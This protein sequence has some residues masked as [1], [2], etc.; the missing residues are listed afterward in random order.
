ML[1]GRKAALKGDAAQH[2]EHWSGEIEPLKASGIESGAIIVDALFG[3]GLARPLTREVIE[4]IL[5]AER[6]GA[7]VYSVDVPSGLDADSG[8]ILGSKAFSAKKTITFQTLKTE[9]LLYPYRLK[10]SNRSHPLVTSTSLNFG[11]IRCRAGRRYL[12][13]TTS[14]MRWL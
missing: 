13:N 11:W 4:V 9:H 8:E 5:A 7:P 14:G 3:A 6:S 10:Q 2:A 1:L 12:I